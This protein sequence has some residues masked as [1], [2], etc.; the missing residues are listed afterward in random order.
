MVCFAHESALAGISVCCSSTC[1]FCGSPLRAMH[2]TVSCRHAV[3][4][5]GPAECSRELYLCF[6]GFSLSS[7]ILRLLSCRL[8]ALRWPLSFAVCN[9]LQTPKQQARAARSTKSIFFD[10]LGGSSGSEDR[11]LMV[12]LLF[13]S[14]LPYGTEPR[15]GW[16]M[17]AAPRSLKAN[18][19]ARPGPTAL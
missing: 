15:E 3:M 16:S 6:L 13:S 11:Y 1:T 10:E 7:P 9:C 2:F 19:P 5:Q 4:G 8:L 12:A 17:A 18:P 14:C